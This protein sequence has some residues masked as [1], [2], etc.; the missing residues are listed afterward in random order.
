MVLYSRIHSIC[1]VCTLQKRVIRIM[2]GV[3]ATNSRR[4]LFKKLYIVLLLCLYILPLMMS[5][6]DNQKHFQT[7]L[8]VHGLDTRSKNQLYLLN[9]ICPDVSEN[10]YTLYEVFPTLLWS[11]ML[12]Q[13]ILRMLGM[14]G[15]SLKLYYINM[16]LIHY[17]HLH[18][19]L[20]I[21]QI[22]HITDILNF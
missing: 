22:I 1:S 3:G 10:K 6:V 17:I 9:F 21:I 13:I 16:V 7:N 4:N 15:W 2:S 14:T 5:V 12:Y 20:S 18:N 19:S 8:P 11:L